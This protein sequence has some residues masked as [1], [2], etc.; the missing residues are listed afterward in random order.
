MISKGL[1]HYIHVANGSASPDMTTVFQAT[2]YG[3]FIEIKNNLRK[4][5]LYQM[6]I[7]YNFLGSN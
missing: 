2:P 3:R 5:K 7:G 6:N 4:R 1:M